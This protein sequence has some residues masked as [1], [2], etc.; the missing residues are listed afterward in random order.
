MNAT[1]ATKPVLSVRGVTLLYHTK[2]HLITA[3]YRVNFD[4][5]ESDRFV[6]LEPSG[7]G[8]STLL[9]AVG[10]YMQPVDGEMLLN[11]ARIDERG[12]DRALVFQEF[13]QLLPGKTVRDNICFALTASGKLQRREAVEKAMHYIDKSDSRNSPRTIRTRSPAA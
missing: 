12:P 1:S 5:L 9:K 2:N 11:G 7:C 6:M 4:V 13:D 10:G 8:K 3:T